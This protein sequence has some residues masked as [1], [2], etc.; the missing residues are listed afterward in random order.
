MRTPFNDLGIYSKEIA[1]VP[2]NNEHVT[3]SVYLD[4]Q[5]LPAFTNLKQSIEHQ[6]WTGRVRQG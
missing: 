5:K 6:A 2:C 4:L 1:R 3:F